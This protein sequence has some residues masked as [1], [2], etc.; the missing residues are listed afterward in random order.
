MAEFRSTGSA[1]RIDFENTYEYQG[2]SFDNIE[3]MV[4]LL[5]FNFHTAQDIQSY[6]KKDVE[7]TLKYA[8]EIA[9]EILD[10]NHPVNPYTHY[11]KTGSL[12]DSV[13]YRTT[14]SHGGT[15]GSIY[16]DAKDSRG[17][18]YG[19]HIEYGFTDRAGIPHG[20]WPFLRPAMRLALSAT[21]YDFAD[22]MADVLTGRFNQGYMSLGSKNARQN[23]QSVFGSTRNAVDYLRSE[24]HGDRN[25]SYQGRWNLAENGIGFKSQVN[26]GY[27]ADSTSWGEGWL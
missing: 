10:T 21:R 25:S 24:F 19:G 3:S 11:K 15:G 1:I 4:G 16:A 7:A 6:T 23:V 27:R 20:P 18:K 12:R 2:H 13:K 5:N 9:K 17:H 8:V 22:T 26:W 14:T